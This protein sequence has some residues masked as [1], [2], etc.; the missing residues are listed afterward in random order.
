MPTLNKTQ[1]NKLTMY[2]AVLSLMGANGVVVTGV[3][4]LKEAKENFDGV[5]QQ[6]KGKGREREQA[7]AGKAAAKQQAEDALVASLMEISSALYSF[8]RKAKKTDVQE[9][10]DVTET[11]LRRMR[12]TELESRAKSIHEKAAIDAGALADYNITAEKMTTLQARIGDFAAAL[13]E[14]ES[15]A[16]G[17]VGL[18]TTV[19]G[20]FDQADE[21]L[22]EDLDR[23]METVRESATD[24]YNKYFSA[25]VIKDLGIRH[26]Q[27]PQ[28]PQQ[29]SAQPTT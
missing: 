13:G 1:E 15:S 12:D 14:R 22:T 24:F 17:R 9:I 3:P 5:V 6:I 27:P 28:P 25:R 7:T 16:A 18:T 11:K 29:P 19:A 21:I 8:S 26:Q 20:L 10:A 2:E 4:A 23:L